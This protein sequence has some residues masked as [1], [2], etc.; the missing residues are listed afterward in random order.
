VN[1]SKS[2]SLS[3]SFWP[4]R[5]QAGRWEADNSN[6]ITLKGNFIMSSVDRSS[7]ILDAQRKGFSVFEGEGRWWLAVPARPRL[8][9]HTQGSWAASDRAWSVACLLA[10]EYP[11]GIGAAQ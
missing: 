1:A 8:P 7:L 9:A 3:S 4:V 5:S 2:L 6:P 10:A 11:V